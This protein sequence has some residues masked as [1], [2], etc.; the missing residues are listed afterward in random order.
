MHTRR[1]FLQFSAALLVRPQA[2]SRRIT[3]L[4]GTGAARESANNPFGLVIGPDGALY[5]AGFGSHRVMRFDFGAKAV[6]VVAGTGKAGYSGDGGAA[7]SAQ[8]N[9]P[10]EVRFD[11]KGNIYVAERDN[12]VVRYIDMKS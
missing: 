12:H 8:L 11:S 6:S 5:W 10:H 3:T 2:G 1:E 7:T 4:V 9:A